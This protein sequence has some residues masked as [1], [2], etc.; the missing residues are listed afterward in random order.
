M[1]T[2]WN[3]NFKKKNGR[4][5]K[6]DLKYVQLFSRSGISTLKNENVIFEKGL[7]CGPAGRNAL[8]RWIEYNYKM[9]NDEENSY[10]AVNACKIWQ[11]TQSFQ[12]VVLSGM[13][14]FLKFLNVP[15]HVTYK[16]VFDNYLS[17]NFINKINSIG[18]SQ[19]R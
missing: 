18:N 2:G 8:I 4:R 13:V 9:K 1:S 12:D 7:N 15:K 3:F 14:D 11:K 6:G 19:K 17:P 16:N 10:P 5:K